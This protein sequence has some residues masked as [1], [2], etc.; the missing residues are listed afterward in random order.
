MSLA[1]PTYQSGS[2]LAVL[3]LYAAVERVSLCYGCGRVPD[4]ASHSGSTCRTRA[5]IQSLTACESAGH[6]LITMARLTSTEPSGTFCAPDFA[7]LEV[8]TG[9][10][11]EVSAESCNP[12]RTI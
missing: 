3:T 8:E 11:S 10:F 1:G 2:R 4:S 7:P 6:E 9:V 5:K 12:S